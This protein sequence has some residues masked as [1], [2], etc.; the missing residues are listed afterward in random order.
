MV[1]KEF[2]KHIKKRV[3]K[4]SEREK[5]ALKEATTCLWLSDSS[6]YK[7][8]LAEVIGIL[9]GRK[10]VS[11]AMELEISDGDYIDTIFETLKTKEEKEEER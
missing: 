10:A 1:N 3:K 2:E 6:D 11:E 9:I 7:G 8:G 5:K 4:L